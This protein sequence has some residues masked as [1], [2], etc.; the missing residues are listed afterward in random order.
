MKVKCLKCDA[1]VEH[2][3]RQIAGCLCDPDAP[4]WVYIELNGKVRGFS[5]SE[6]VEVTDSGE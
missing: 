2:N 5:Q 3:P 6:W 1:I 4:T